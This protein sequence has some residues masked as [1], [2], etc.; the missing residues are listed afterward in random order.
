PRPVHVA[1]SLQTIDFLASGFGS[2]PS[3]VG[4]HP[5]GGFVRPLVDCAFFRAEERVLALPGDATAEADDG[6]RSVCSVLTCVAGSGTIDT[7]GGA[8]MLSPMRTI[9]VPA[10]AHGFRAR[11]THPDFRLLRAVPRF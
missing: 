4:P 3:N 9:L 8:A 10:A 6:P 5:S 2:L 11:A 7:E 1:E